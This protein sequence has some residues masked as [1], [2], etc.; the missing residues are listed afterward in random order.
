M[1]FDFPQNRMKVENE[2]GEECN[3]NFSNANDFSRK[4]QDAFEKLP[5]WWSVIHFF[6]FR[7]K[8]DRLPQELQILLYL[9]VP[10]ASETGTALL[11]NFPAEETLIFN[12]L[13][14]RKLILLEIGTSKEEKIG[15]IAVSVFHAVST[16]V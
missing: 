2:A 14:F 13:I 7:G 15:K 9:D 11:P 1:T 3:G 8:I 10:T 12:N 16:G 5:L 6:S 4:S